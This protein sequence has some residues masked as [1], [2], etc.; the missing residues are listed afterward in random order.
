M[1]ADECMKRQ[2]MQKRFE[3]KYEKHMKVFNRK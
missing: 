3:Y 1:S 2:L